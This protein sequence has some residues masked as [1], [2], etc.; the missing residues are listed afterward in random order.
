MIDPPRPPSNNPPMQRT[1]LLSILLSACLTASTQ[2]EPW[3]ATRVWVAASDEH[4]WVI[5]AADT[6]ESSM[7]VLQIWY[8]GKA[9]QSTVPALLPTLPPIEGNPNSLAAD[10]EA[11]R[12]L[13]ADLNQVDYF[14]NKPLAPGAMWKDQCR[15]SPLA[16]TGDTV[17]PIIWAIVSA[18]DLVTPTTQVADDEAEPGTQ[19]TTDRN[20]LQRAVAPILTTPPTWGHVLLRQENGVWARASNIDMAEGAD[21]FWLAARDGVVH[22][23]WKRDTDVLLSTLATAISDIGDTEGATKESSGTAVR[24]ASDAGWSK[25]EVVLKG[26]DVRHAWAGVTPKSPMFVVAVASGDG[27]ASHLHVYAGDEAG[28]WSRQAIVRENLE[29]MQVDPF[30]VSVATLSKELAIA[31]IATGGIVEY[32]VADYETWS[33]VRCEPLSMRRPDPVRPTGWRESVSLAIA[34]AV[35]TLVMWTRRQQLMMQI[36]LPAG[37]IPAAIWRRIMATLL[38]FAP[39]MLILSPLALRA[40]PELSQS[41]DLAMLREILNDPQTQARLLPIHYAT[42]LVYGLW[43]LIWEALIGTTPGKYL[44]GCRVISVA[45]A[46]Y[47]PAEAV[48]DD[49]ETKSPASDS[50]DRRMN[51][52]TSMVRSITGTRPNFRQL[53]VRNFCRV[54][55]VSIGSPGWIITLMMMGM[56]SRNRQRIGDLMAAT[57]VVEESAPVEERPS[58]DEPRDGPFE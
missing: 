40:V 3:Q 4:T 7:A 27:D 14:P 11:L 9:T 37:I 25:S 55:M 58:S 51:E 39:A 32:G 15:R 50:D 31:R 6:A 21:R 20:E 19:A 35:L 30:R 47:I 56:L 18:H 2:A 33:P 57:M 5:G 28:R 53:L 17:R 34:L 45:E 43:C 48:D 10:A 42:V 16:W 49:S 22:L 8:A 24:L 38:D 12:I 44:F 1:L 54:I 46:N 23:F 26:V 41:S 52:Q 13:Y 29:Y 36:E